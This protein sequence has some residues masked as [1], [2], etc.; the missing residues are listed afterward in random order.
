MEAVFEITVANPVR[1]QVILHRDPKLE[2]GARNSPPEDDSEYFAPDFLD[3]AEVYDNPAED[4]DTL[5]QNLAGMAMR[6]FH[7]TDENFEKRKA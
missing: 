5:R 2:E 6:T 3:T 7:K 4:C 1:L